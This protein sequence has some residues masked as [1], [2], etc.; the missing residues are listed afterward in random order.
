MEVGNI[1]SGKSLTVHITFTQRLEVVA[2]SLALL[3]SPTFIPRTHVSSVAPGAVSTTPQLAPDSTPYTW[4]V[5]VNVEAHGKITGLLCDSHR[6]NVE[7]APD[8]S[9]ALLLME[10][11]GSPDKAFTLLYR[12]TGMTQPRLYFQ[13]PPH[14]KWEGT[15]AAMVSFFPDFLHHPDDLGTEETAELQEQSP[16]EVEKVMKIQ[17]TNPPKPRLTEAHFSFVVDENLLAGELA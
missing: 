13:P 14:N 12:S 4:E 11:P 15:I 1:E 6:M 10:E 3:L 7:Y 16:A 2:G 9:R 8:H 5:R 17:L